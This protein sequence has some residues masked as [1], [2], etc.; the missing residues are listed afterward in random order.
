MSSYW[1]WVLSSLGVLGMILAGK[2]RWEGWAIGLVSEGLWMV[3]A[4]VTHQLGFVLGAL[5]YGGVF[6][7]NLLSWKRTSDEMTRRSAVP[8]WI[9]DAWARNL[10]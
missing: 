8:G 4:I 9:I 5:A 6:T 7:K 1:G 10:D 3:Y 2:K